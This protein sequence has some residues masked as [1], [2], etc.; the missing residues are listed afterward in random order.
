MAINY[1]LEPHYMYYKFWGN[2]QPTIWSWNPLRSHSTDIV[3]FKINIYTLNFKTQSV[4]VKNNN[5]NYMV[6]IPNLR[7]C[8]YFAIRTINNVISNV[9]TNVNSNKHWLFIITVI[10]HYFQQSST[11]SPLLWNQQKQRDVLYK[12]YM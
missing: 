9:I 2:H 5:Q 6:L 7:G 12:S 1:I 3:H 4:N 11:T 8:S 10:W